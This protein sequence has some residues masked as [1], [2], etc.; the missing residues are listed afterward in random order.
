VIFGLSN[1]ASTSELC[2]NMNVVR[3]AVLYRQS[4]WSLLPHVTIPP[5]SDKQLRLLLR[6]GPR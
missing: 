5:G 2:C 4:T 1:C 6:A 3:S